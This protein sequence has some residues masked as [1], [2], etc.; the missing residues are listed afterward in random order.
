MKSVLKWNYPI[1]P[2]RENKF[3]ISNETVS[4]AGVI[5][6]QAI[7]KQSIKESIGKNFLVA[8]KTR[9]I[10]QNKFRYANI[11]FRLT[12]LGWQGWRVAQVTPSSVG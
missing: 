2:H 6:T 11:N 10:S 4:A 3:P 7:S 5:K 12:V 1:S 9:F 8:I